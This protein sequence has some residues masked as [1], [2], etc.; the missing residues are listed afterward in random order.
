M[1]GTKAGEWKREG[2]G[3]NPQDYKQKMQKEREKNTQIFR[4][5]KEM[6]LQCTCWQT[7]KLRYGWLAGWLAVGPPLRKSKSQT[8]CIQVGRWVAR[9]VAGKTSTLVK[10]YLWHQERKRFPRLSLAWCLVLN[11]PSH[12]A[13]SWGCGC[14]RLLSAGAPPG[15]LRLPQ[16][17][18]RAWV[19][20]CITWVPG[21]A[22][23]G[24]L[25]G[26]ERPLRTSVPGPCPLH[27]AAR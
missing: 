22:T 12:P 8:G 19:G 15:P 13:Q 17:C 1:L 20:V 10:W 4:D 14:P 25:L 18:P 26:S 21:G 7:L 6:P 3:R 11:P 24:L 5:A 16:P 9:Q 2:E 23:L 27:T